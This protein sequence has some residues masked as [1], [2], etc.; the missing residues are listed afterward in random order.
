[1]LFLFPLF[2]SYLLI[3]GLKTLLSGWSA[4]LRMSQGSRVFE[5]PQVKEVLY[6]EKVEWSPLKIQDEKIPILVEFPFKSLPCR[7]VLAELESLI[8]YPTTQT[9]ADI[10]K[11]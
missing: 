5:N 2:D 10:P 7:K 3:R 9:H 6:T 8:T 4:P 11:W 1:M